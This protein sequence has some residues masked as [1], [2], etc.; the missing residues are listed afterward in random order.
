[1]I[2]FELIFILYFYSI[3]YLGFNLLL[4]YIFILRIR[5]IDEEEN[6]LNLYLYKLCDLYAN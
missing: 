5:C 3:V 4:K 6:N 2:K 1:M